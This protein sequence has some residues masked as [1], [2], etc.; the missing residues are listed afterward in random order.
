MLPRLALPFAAALL[1]APLWPA[2]AGAQERPS[3]DQRDYR[4]WIDTTVAFDRDGTV[5]L[6]HLTGE[7]VVTTWDRPQVRLLAYAEH[8]EIDARISRGRIIVGL[9]PDEDSTGRRRR[10]VRVGDSRFEITVPAGTRVKAGNLSGNVRIEGV[11]GEVEAST[12]SGSITA[13]D[14]AGGT[15]LSSVSGNVT[16][17]DVTGDVS[18]TSVSGTVSLRGI[19]GDVRTSTVSGTLTLRDVRARSVVAGTTSGRVT[20]EGPLDRAGRYEFTSHS[21]SVSLLLPSTVGADLSVETYSGA[22]DTDFPVTMGPATRRGAR[23]RSMELTLGDGGAR[24]VAQSFS[25]NIL[26]KRAAG[27]PERP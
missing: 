26:L 17:I 5:Q 20:F 13:S 18:A 25:G 3:R 2:G 16:A 8:A 11:R 12:M 4:T 9:E 7:I 22:L 23:P 15:T 10:S 21:G 19:T 1:A 24:V 27:A 14:V 6:D